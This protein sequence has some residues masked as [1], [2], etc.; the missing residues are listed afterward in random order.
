MFWID[1]SIRQQ[2]LNPG[3]DFNDTIPAVYE[4]FNIANKYCHANRYYYHAGNGNT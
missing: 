1:S 4:S 3:Q 2:L